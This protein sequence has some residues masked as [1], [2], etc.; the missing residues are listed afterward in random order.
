[1]QLEIF[2]NSKKEAPQKTVLRVKGKIQK[3]EKAPQKTDQGFRLSLDDQSLAFHYVKTCKM[4]AVYLPL[5][6]GLMASKNEP[7]TVLELAK[8]MREF[9]YKKEIEYSNKEKQICYFQKTDKTE[10]INLFKEYPL[11]KD[12]VNKLA[13]IVLDC[14]RKA[15]VSNGILPKV[16]MMQGSGKSQL[17][18]LLE[19]QLSDDQRK[20]LIV[21]CSQRI[22]QWDFRIGVKGGE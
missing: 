9:F 11:E 5:L 13:S 19:G 10:G 12:Q 20:D 3:T 16:K 7:I 22:E 1:M 6:I 18:V 8:A 4:G 2:E 15:L 17:W 14:P 21:L